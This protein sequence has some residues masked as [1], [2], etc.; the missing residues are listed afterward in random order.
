MLAIKTEEILARLV[1]KEPLERFLAEVWTANSKFNLF[2]RQSN[3]AD[4]RRII[5]ESLIPVDLGWVTAESGP[6]LDIGSGW[7]IPSI[8]LLLAYPG[9]RFT[10][11][12]RSK[13]K[14]D[15][16]LLLLNRLGIKAMVFSGELSDHRPETAYR[17]ITLRRVAFDRRIMADICNCLAPDGSVISFGP[18][19][20]DEPDIL[21]ELVTYTID[22]LPSR[23][24]Y[25]LTDF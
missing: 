24:L 10:L 2:S 3:Q 11:I 8:P 22:D 25:R 13:K 21:R 7:G 19:L 18:H 20:P 14:A 6:A 9:V 1:P 23:K 12:E 5:A 4:L 15:F 17:L 16:L